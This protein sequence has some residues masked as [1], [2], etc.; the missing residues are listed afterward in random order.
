MRL[1]GF[2]LSQRPAGVCG[3]APWASRKL[4][5]YPG[6]RLSITDEHLFR[7]GDPLHV[8]KIKA[9]DGLLKDEQTGTRYASE[10]TVIR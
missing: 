2:V 3:T 5:P 4:R 8:Y 10:I 9:V 6:R 1:A 7:F